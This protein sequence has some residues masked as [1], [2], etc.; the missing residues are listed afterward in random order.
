VCIRL[1]ERIETGELL[2]CELFLND[3]NK[4]SFLGRVVRLTEYDSKNDVYKYEIGV[5]FEKIEERDRERIIGYI[6]QE[7]RRLIKK[8]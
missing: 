5:K 6:F 1:K 8:G 4:V 3:F 7:Q 2:E